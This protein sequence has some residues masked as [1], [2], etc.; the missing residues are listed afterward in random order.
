MPKVKVNTI[1]INYEIQGSGPPLL[2]IL[3]LG[4]NITWWG[5]YFIK[6]LADYFKVIVFDNRGTGQSSTPKMQYSVKTLANDAFGLLKTLNIE[7]TFVFGHS[8]GGGIAQ[9]LII[10]YNGISKL[11]LCNSSCGGSKSILASSEVLEVIDKTRSGRASDEI[12]KESLKIFYSPEFMKNNPKLIDYAVQNM[13]K[14]QML[15]RNYEWQTTAIKSFKTCDR[16]KN[17]KIPTLIM[18][19]A[20]DVLVPPQNTKILA[21]LIPNAHIKMFTESAH[22]PYVEEPDA[23]I[24]AMVEFLL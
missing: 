13:A 7:N 17:I 12:A 4:A 2:M 21:E 19:G 14:S 6:G 3:G 11:I 23:V 1:N 10:Q 18:H 8:M 9:E 16:I 22:A 15:S 24:D 5:N 20:K